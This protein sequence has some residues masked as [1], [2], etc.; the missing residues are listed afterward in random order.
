[1]TVEEE[2]LFVPLSWTQWSQCVQLVPRCPTHTDNG[3][4]SALGWRGKVGVRSDQDGDRTGTGRG[5]DRGLDC[6]SGGGD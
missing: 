4:Y 2:P 5:Q 6:E 1:M 3:D